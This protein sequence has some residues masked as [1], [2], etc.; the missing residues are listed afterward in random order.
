MSF[1]VMFNHSPDDTRDRGGCLYLAESPRA[2]RVASGACQ[3]LGQ[4]PHRQMSL[5]LER[6]CLLHLGWLPVLTPP[7]WERL[8]ASR[9]RNIE[10]FSAWVIPNILG[11]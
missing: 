5:V 1:T 2:A 3:N 7:P 9:N 8:L 11:F 6:I 10:M 4:T